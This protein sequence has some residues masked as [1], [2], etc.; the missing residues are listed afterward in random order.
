M[1]RLRE[2]MTTDMLVV[3]PET[4]LR[5]AMELLGRHHV[6]GAPVVSGGVLIGVVTG[7]D[8]MMFASA[9]SGVPTEHEAADEWFDNDVTGDRESERDQEP[10]SAFFSE[11][12]DDAGADVAGRI[13]S[14]AGPEWNVLEEHDVSEAMTRMPLATLTPDA[15][16]AL[17]AEMMTRRRVHRVLVTEGDTLVG[18]VSALDIAKAVADG[19]LTK[20]TYVF[21]HD[22]GF[23][24]TT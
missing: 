13:V 10:A 11:L 8:L 6:S 14:I 20:R 17:A 9:L 21:N 4:T 15:D 3:T 19:K 16:A 24:E 5:E 18:I 23:E 22:R 12:W 2:I 1:V 7:T